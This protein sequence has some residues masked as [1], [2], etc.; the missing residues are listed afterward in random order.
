[1]KSL[2]SPFAIAFH[3][4]H[5]ELNPYHRLSGRIIYSLLILHASFYMNFFIQ[6]GLVVVRLS[7]VVPLLGVL[8]FT[9]ITILA[10]TSL[11]RIRQWSYRVFFLCHLVIGVLI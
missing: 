5:E 1:M 8:A 9:L 2:Y 4:S 11:E 10:S 7:Q 3:A 6:T